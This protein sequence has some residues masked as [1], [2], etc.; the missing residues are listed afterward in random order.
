M[1]HSFADAEACLVLAEGVKGG[2]SGIE[3]MP[4]LIV[5]EKDKTHTAEVVR[6]LEGSRE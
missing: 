1:I 5:Y 2:K 3:V 4:P 6:M